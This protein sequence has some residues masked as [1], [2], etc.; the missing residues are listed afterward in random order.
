MNCEH[1]AI[2]RNDEEHQCAIYSALEEAAWDEGTVPDLIWSY[3]G[4]DTGH[5]TWKVE[6]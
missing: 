6:P 5:C 1:C 3:M 2:F 4:K